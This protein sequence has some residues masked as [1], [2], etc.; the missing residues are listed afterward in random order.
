ML[1]I[2]AVLFLLLF[3][4]AAIYLVVDRKLR[5]VDDR[6]APIAAAFLA[7][8]VQGMLVLLGSLASMALALAVCGYAAALLFRCRRP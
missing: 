6:F 4:P 5:A 2:P 3:P 8:L 7:L 1:W